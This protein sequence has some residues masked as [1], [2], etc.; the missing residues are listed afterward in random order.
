MDAELTRKLAHLLRSRRTAALG[1]LHGVE[2]RAGGGRVHTE[3]LQ[4][5][6]REDLTLG[7]AV[8]LLVFFAFAM[9]CVSTIAVVRR[10]TGGWGYPAL[11][12]GY[13]LTLAYAGAWVANVVVTYFVG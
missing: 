8:A 2:S 6:L 5:A 9:Q 10:E 11:Q 13:M 3:G 7:G 1:T 4:A 12:F